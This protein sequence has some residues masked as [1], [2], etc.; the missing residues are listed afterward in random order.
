MKRLRTLTAMIAATI[1][2]GQSFGQVPA[3]GG[4][5]YTAQDLVEATAKVQSEAESHNCEMAVAAMIN[6]ARTNMSNQETMLQLSVD[7]LNLLTTMAT[8]NSPEELGA[9]ARFDHTLEGAMKIDTQVLTSGISALRSMCP[10][11]FP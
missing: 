8:E 1:V 3:G 6:L 9:L 4:T 7:K 11:A 2:G 10:D 5:I